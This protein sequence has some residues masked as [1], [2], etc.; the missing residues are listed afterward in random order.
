MPTARRC[1]YLCADDLDPSIQSFR[2]LYDP[3]GRLVEPHIT[4]VFPFES[5]VSDDELR[6]HVREQVIAESGFA[7]S[8]EQQPMRHDGYIYF[9]ILDGAQQIRTI[10]DR[11]YTGVLQP[12]LLEI[13]YVPH[14]TVARTTDAEEKQLLRESSSLEFDNKFRI[15]K[16]KIE[17]VLHDDRGQLIYQILFRSGI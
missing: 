10:H 8:L 12:L 9:P 15:S 2:E 6:A 14:V 3:L 1:I 7:A 11:L 4:V 17:R 13:P 16:L 5:N